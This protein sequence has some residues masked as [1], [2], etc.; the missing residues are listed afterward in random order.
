MVEL[1]FH[2]PRCIIKVVPLHALVISQGALRRVQGMNFILQKIQNERSAVN[3]DCELGRGGIT[4]FVVS[5]CVV[6][7]ATKQCAINPIEINRLTLARHLR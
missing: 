6:A 4:D 7:F 2:Q 5:G 3:F 1:S